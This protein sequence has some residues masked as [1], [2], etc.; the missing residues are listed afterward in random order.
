M[1]VEDWLA[2]LAAELHR[3]RIDPAEVVAEAAAHLRDSGRP[4]MEVFGPP[5]AYAVTVVDSIRGTAPPRD[6]GA[7]RLQASNISKRYGRTTV[8]T[9]VNLSVHAGEAVA[10]IGGNGSGKSTFLRICAGL[11]SPDEGQ[12]RLRGTIGYCPQDGGTAGFLTPDEH[13][14]LVGAGRGIRRTASI[15]QGRTAAAALDWPRGHAA[16]PARHLSGGT[17]QKLN[18]V[19]AGLGDPDV[20]LLDEPYQGFDNGSYLDF[21]QQV[22]QWRDAGKAIVVVTHRLAELDRADTVLDLSPRNQR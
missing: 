9:G 1:T 5:T 21:W 17:R 8:L 2:A 16:K 12:V 13:F 18:L 14:V 15:A 7:P 19:L 10:V 22:W 11:D 3:R 6:R 20:L 4:P